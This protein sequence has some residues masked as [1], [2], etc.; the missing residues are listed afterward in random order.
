M[1]LENIRHDGHPAEIFERVSQWSSVFCH[2]QN[3]QVDKMSTDAKKKMWYPNNR[4]FGAPKRICQKEIIYFT[5]VMSAREVITFIRTHSENYADYGIYSWSWWILE[6][7]IY[8]WQSSWL[9]VPH[10]ILLRENPKYN[11]VFDRIFISV[12]GLHGT[13]MSSETFKTSISLSTDMILLLSLPETIEASGSLEA[14]V[15]FL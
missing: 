6:Y 9:M 5:I 13:C 15:S 4:L 12:Q 7:S 8:L 10:A 11:I 2:L 3:L 14:E 1:F